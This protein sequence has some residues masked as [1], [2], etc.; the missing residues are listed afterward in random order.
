MP[1]RRLC[2][3]RKADAKGGKSPGERH[4]MTGMLEDKH[5]SAGHAVSQN[6]KLHTPGKVKGFAATRAAGDEC[7]LICRE[8]CVGVVFKVQ[9]GDAQRPRESDWHLAEADAIFNP[10]AGCLIVRAG[11]SQVEIVSKRVDFVSS[12]QLRRSHNAQVGCCVTMYIGQMG[13]A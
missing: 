3:L 7:W 11:V 2:P 8:W 9:A 5:G 4:S 1:A 6:L 13:R 12:G 10:D